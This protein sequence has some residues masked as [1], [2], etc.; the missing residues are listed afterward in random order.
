MESLHISFGRV[1]N[2]GLYKGVTIDNS[3]TISHLFYADDVVFVGE[4][5]ASNL[6]TIVKVLNCFFLASGLKINMHKSK[7][8]GSG[9]SSEEVESAARIVGCSTFTSP[10]NYLGVKVGGVMSRIK[11]WDEV[12]CK[13]SSRLSK[14]KIKTLSIGGRLTLLKS[15]LSS[16]PLYHMSIFKVPMGVLK[17][18]ESIR[19]IFFNGDGSSNRKMAWVCW[20]KVLASK[21]KG[22]LGVSSFFALNRALLFK[23]VWRFI[24]QGSSLWSRFIKAIHGVRGALDCSNLSSRASPWLDIIRELNSLKS[25]GVDLMTL[26]RKKV[27][28]GVDTLF[29]DEVWLGNNAL[30]CQFPRLY[31]LETHKNISIADKMHHDSV[32]YSLR[33]SPRGGVEEEQHNELLSY[34]AGLILPQTHDRWFW[35]L[36]STGEFSV[37]SVRNLLDD[38]FLS[39]DDVPSRWVK[40]IPIKVNVFAWRVRLDSLPTRLNLS[41]RGLEI[42]SIVCPLCNVVAESTSHL[43]FSCSLARQV[44]SKVMRWWELDDP[45]IS[46]YDEWLSWFNNIRLPMPLKDVLEGICYVKWWLVWRFR[47]QMIFGSSLPRKD[48]LFDDIVRLSFTWCSSRCKSKFNWVTWMQ[49]PSLSSL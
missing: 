13:L 34:L 10:F 4:W 33:R 36:E 9:V 48:V 19:I 5:D 31:A 32:V 44:R 40:V 16:I 41:L 18:M 20:D 26:V 21:K 27:G 37:K 22:G 42:P 38:S 43:L 39:V 17:N 23:W 2:A 11:S 49:N 6:N 35:S 30:K 28:N 1:L 8:M 14:W 24:S 12:T 29:W 25:K 46:S 45:D 3:L 15:V 7:L 47:N